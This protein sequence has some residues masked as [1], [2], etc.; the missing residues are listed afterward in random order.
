MSAAIQHLFDRLKNGGY[1]TAQMGGIYAN[2]PGY[3]N[4]RD[5]LPPSDY[6]VQL[7]DDQLGSGGN[8]AALDITLNPAD[9]PRLTQR[10]IDLTV[11]RDARIQT[12]REFFG[13]TDGRTV[14]GM[15]V[16]DVRWETSDD[17]HLWH[18]H[19]S[20]FR[21]FAGDQYAM[22]IVAD[23]ILDVPSSGPPPETG[24]GGTNPSQE[25]DEL[26]PDQWTYVQTQLNE[27]RRLTAGTLNPSFLQENYAPGEYQ[28]A[29]QVTL[30]GKVGGASVESVLSEILTTVR[31]LR[32]GQT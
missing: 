21:R 3:H 12:L 2:K 28:I 23:A 8:A 18:V 30:L 13:T 9:M 25:D 32:A 5:N 24:G 15:D 29:D 4:K 11:A 1:P 6:S 31:E 22:D 26:T 16:R 14:V 27:I 17:S 7:P 20:V 19:I 10:L